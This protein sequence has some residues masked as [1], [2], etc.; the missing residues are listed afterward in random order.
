MSSDAVA[1]LVRRT[2]A[3]VGVSFHAA[4]A[5]PHV[6]DVG[7]AWQ[8]AVGGVSRL[9]THTSVET[10]SGTYLHPSVEDLRDALSAAGMLESLGELL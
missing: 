3:R 1:D 9:V 8:G 5:A 4:H 7:D 6:C 10:T 2:R